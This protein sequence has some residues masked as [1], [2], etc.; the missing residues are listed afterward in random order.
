MGCMISVNSTEHT[1]DN[2]GSYSECGREE[3]R[4]K[5]SENALTLSLK[6]LVSLTQ[7][8]SWRE[9][10]AQMVSRFAPDSEG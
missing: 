2:P 5:V 4:L 3:V 7:G 1:L 6:P 8:G 9:G 10:E